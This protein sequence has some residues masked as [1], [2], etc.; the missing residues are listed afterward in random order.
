MAQPK[1]QLGV[2]EL[3]L[4]LQLKEKVSALQW[5]ASVD[6]ILKE[7]I[8]RSKIA[9]LFGSLVTMKDKC[10]QGYTN[11]LTVE[12]Y[13]WY[14]CIAWHE[15]LTNMGVCVK[16]SAHSWAAYQEEYKENFHEPINVAEF[17]R[18]VQGDI[19][20]TRLSRID[21]VA[22]YKNYGLSLSPDILYQKIKDKEYVIQNFKGK[23]IFHKTSSIEN[24]GSTET[25][26]IGSR[27]ANVK[28]S[29]RVYDKK[30]EQLKKSGFRLQE[31]LECEDWT[32]FEASYRGT[33]AHQITDA[34]LKDVHSPSELQNFIAHKFME[35]FQFYDKKKDDVTDFTDDLAGLMKGTGFSALRAESARNNSLKKSINYLMNGSGLFP[36]IYKVGYIWGED[37]E[38]ELLDMMYQRYQRRFVPT[39]GDNKDL[40]HWLD[41]N[42][43]ETRKQSL[44]DMFF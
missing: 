7:F 26:Y 12:G 11:G 6:E 29:L 4:V 15:Y 28:L 34:L 5:L 9:K 13:S 31:A 1:L 39:A 25:F 36:T 30:Y 14:F 42:A 16:F 35:K 22:D 33:Y 41:K 19:Y 32:R 18:M 24:N 10:P 43:I 27:K 40:M 3:T 20:N 2:D 23:E 8:D 21:L 17:L 37:A 38:E 44:N